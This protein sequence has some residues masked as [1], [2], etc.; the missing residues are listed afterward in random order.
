MSAAGTPARTMVFS[1]YWD[2]EKNDG[3]TNPLNIID[4]KNQIMM[5]KK[6]NNISELCND[7]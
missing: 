5:C 3:I 2:E 6:I 1:G 4:G 7:Y